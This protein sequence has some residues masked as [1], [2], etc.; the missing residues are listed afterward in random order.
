M[1][2]PFMLNKGDVVLT[3]FPYSDLSGFKFRPAVI[4]S[5]G[6]IGQEVIAIAISTN[7]RGATIAPFDIP[8]DTTNPE[9]SQSGLK[10][11]SVLRA[12]KLV[13]LDES[14]LL[15][16]L[17]KLGAKTSLAVDIQLRKA[18]SL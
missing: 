7:Q 9:F 1:S 4:V 17:G 8:L 2:H 5:P 13:T 15:R 6:F 14:L 10:F 12:D 16:R 3:K 11:P 18:L